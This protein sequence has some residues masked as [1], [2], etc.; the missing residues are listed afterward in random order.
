MSGDKPK[1]SLWLI[2]NYA[3]NLGSQSWLE[4]KTCSWRDARVNLRERVTFS[5]V[6]VPNSF[7]IH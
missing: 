1:L 2:T 4:V 6:L 7:P 3:G 5:T